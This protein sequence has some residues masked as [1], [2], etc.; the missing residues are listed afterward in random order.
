[1]TTTVKDLLQNRSDKGLWTLPPDITVLDALQIM[2][3]HNVGA[4]PVVEGEQLIGL[5][6]ERDYA[7]KIILQGR[8][9]NDTPVRDVMTRE[10]IAVGLDQTLDECMALMTDNHIRHLPV[11][12]EGKLVSHISMRDL[13]QWMIDAQGSQIHN[14]QNFIEGTGYGQ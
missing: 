13:M 4:M 14:L 8:H 3:D 11:V 1:M 12:E 6:S 5:F 7:R 2:S 9:S 10:V